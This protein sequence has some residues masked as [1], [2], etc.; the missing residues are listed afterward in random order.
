MIGMNIPPSHSYFDSFLS[1]YERS[2]EGEECVIRSFIALVLCAL[3][4]FGMYW[5]SPRRPSE[6]LEVSVIL[7]QICDITDS[8]TIRGE[9]KELA[10]EQ[11]FAESL[12]TVEHIY[13]KVGQQVQEGDALMMLRPTSDPQS[14]S[15]ARYADLEAA[16]EAIAETDPE[17]WKDVLTAMAQTEYEL[18]AEQDAQAYIL[19][20]PAS[21]TVMNISAEKGESVST[22]FPCVVISDL[23]YLYVRAYA[24][25]TAIKK[26]QEGQD[27]YVSISALADQP[28]SGRISL[29]S[30][31]ATRTTTLLSGSQIRTEV[32][33]SLTGQSL[34]LRPGYAASVRV[35][36]DR[37]KDAILVPFDAIGQDTDGNEYVMLLR[38]G[39]AYKQ[40][41][42]TRYEL[43]SQA[44]VISGVLPDDL[45]IL[46]PE[47]VEN[48]Q[49]VRAL[50]SN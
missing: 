50:A 33:V 48:G 24:D 40:I 39:R 20:S 43:E 38:E 27:C 10:R 35:I 12:S 42:E 13:V 44:D 25:E 4:I 30:P 1:K 32:T 9:V 11:V 29:I 47:T 46:E 5:I 49:E 36:T 45:L 19:Y 3:L 8:V 6:A 26:L 31:E 18:P 17:E 7:P 16:A 15:A 14:V 21:G 22:L 37:C 41:I 34:F 2:M 23:H 28:V